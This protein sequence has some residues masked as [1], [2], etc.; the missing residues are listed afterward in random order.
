MTLPS[1]R[2]T[3]VISSCWLQRGQPGPIATRDDAAVT[4][5]EHPLDN[6]VWHALT[7][8]H[9][10]FAQRLGGA[11]RYDPE[12]SPFTALHDAPDAGDWDALATLL[13]S[14][15]PAF[16]A[17]RDA[18]LPPDWRVLARFIAVQMVAPDPLVEPGRRHEA[19]PAF[20]RLGT[21]DLPAMTELVARTEPGPWAKRTIELGT[22]IGVFESTA[23]GDRALIAM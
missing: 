23:D 8:P 11:A 14:E 12:V 19:D 5:P 16:I 6:V 22:Y 17:R 2:S 13:G 1:A 7:G 15:T 9:A 20:R 21:A 3:A 18:E 4:K 10:R